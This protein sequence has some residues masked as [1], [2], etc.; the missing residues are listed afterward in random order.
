MAGAITELDK[1]KYYLKKIRICNNKQNL[2]MRKKLLGGIAM[3]AIAAIMA[4]NIN[5]S[6]KNN[7]LSDISLANVEALATTELED[8]CCYPCFGSYCGTIIIGGTG[9]A[10]NKP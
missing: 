6:V 3:L 4:L 1:G 9:F 2:D 5:F 8:G 10:L 7:N